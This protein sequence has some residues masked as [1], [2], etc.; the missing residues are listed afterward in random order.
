M[1]TV[2]DLTALRLE[3]ALQQREHLGPRILGVS[4]GSSANQCVQ[5]ID[6]ISRKAMAK[7]AQACTCSGVCSALLASIHSPWSC[8]SAKYSATRI[9]SK[10]SSGAVTVHMPAHVPTRACMCGLCEQTHAQLPGQACCGHLPLDNL[11]RRRKQPRRVDGF[12]H[13]KEMRTS[14]RKIDDLCECLRRQRWAQVHRPGQVHA[15]RPNCAGVPQPPLV[16]YGASH[17][18][19]QARRIRTPWKSHKSHDRRHGGRPHP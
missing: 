19:Q 8:G 16:T 15:L 3:R 4:S 11:K 9:S 17:T 14:M 7:R 2:D 18:L 10:I 13:R 12:E 5:Q 6:P 1:C